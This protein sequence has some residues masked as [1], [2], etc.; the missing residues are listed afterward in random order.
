M[1][2]IAVALFAVLV[3]VWAAP[4]QAQ[5]TWDG[6]IYNKF[7][8][9][10]DRL[11]TGLY[12]YTDIPG[13]GY[14]DSGQGTQLELFLRGRFAKKVEFRASIQSRFNRNFWTNAGGFAGF[15]CNGGVDPTNPNF[16]ASEFDPRSNQY[17]K[18]RGVQMIF[19]PGYKW[20]DA[21][22]IGENDLGI[23][24][25]MVI[26][27]I[28]Y[29]DRF[30][31]AA[32]QF[33][34]NLDK[35]RFTWDAIRISTPLYLGIDNTIGQFQPQDGTYGLQ[36]K[37]KI[38]SQADVGAIFE[39]ANDIEVDVNDRIVDNGRSLATRYHNAVVG[40]KAGIHPNSM[41]DIGAAFYHASSEANPN[42]GPKS[43]GLGGFAPVLLGTNDGNSYR[44]DVDINDPFQN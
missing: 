22:V 35:R 33:S 9:G 34:G 29:I 23:Y 3:F 41:F 13:E 30:N 43:Y 11:G 7:L 4:A 12:N 44:V 40:L 27:K 14:G 18:L 37:F 36:G 15:C 2:R 25:P 42:Y 31:I 28:R 32:I 21:A 19:T 5:I 1:K 6:N 38:S 17:I 20:F 39:Y 8:W 16:Y 24:D 26:G 10:T